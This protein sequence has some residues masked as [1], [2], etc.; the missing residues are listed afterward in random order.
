MI[1]R[2]LAT[3]RIKR[4]PYRDADISRA[5]ARLSYRIASR[6]LRQAIHF[7]EQ[8]Q[9]ALDTAVRCRDPHGRCLRE[10]AFHRQ[11]RVL[12]QTVVTTDLRQLRDFL[13]RRILEPEGALVLGCIL[14][15]ADRE[16]SAVFWWQY[17]AG[18]GA[19]GGACCLYLHHMGYGERLEAEVWREQA[20]LEPPSHS[21]IPEWIDREDVLGTLHLLEVLRDGEPRRF[22]PAVAA[23]LA[24]VPDAVDEVDGV[25]LPLPEPDFP[26]RIE[27][28]TAI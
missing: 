22:S 16:D 26:S 5:E 17:A 28:L 23:V 27:K 6:T 7:D 3:A 10:G 13:A 4:P 8:A 18:A 20:G 21:G 24:Y 14:Y 9:P 12:A 2:S 25:E 11:L 1:E 19:L 15:L